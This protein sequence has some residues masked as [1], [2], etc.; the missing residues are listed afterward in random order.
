MNSVSRYKVTR[1]KAQQSSGAAATFTGTVCLFPGGM[2][3]TKGGN[4]PRQNCEVIYPV[5]TGILTMKGLHLSE[6]S[7]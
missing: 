1:N 3:K 5:W 7:G 6:G 2:L 4:K